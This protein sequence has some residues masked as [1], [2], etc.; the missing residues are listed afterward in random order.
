MGEIQENIQLSDNSLQK[1]RLAEK[2]FQ[3]ESDGSPEALLDKH[4]AWLD[5]ELKKIGVD[6][7]KREMHSISY[8]NA[9]PNKNDSQILDKIYDQAKAT[10]FNISTALIWKFLP[11]YASWETPPTITFPARKLLID[12]AN[13]KAQI[14]RNI[15]TYHHFNDNYKSPLRGYKPKEGENGD[16]VLT[17]NEHF[18]GPR[19]HITVATHP[20]ESE[21][22]WEYLRGGDMVVIKV[23]PR[24]LA[25]W[26]PSYKWDR[27][28]KQEFSEAYVGSIYG[29]KLLHQLLLKLREADTNDK[30]NARMDTF[31][32]YIK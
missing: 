9:I 20:N 31:G 1:L 18:E 24:M 19:G 11:H 8:D 13:I 10:C 5:A 2:F 28:K 7:R 25:G 30:P 15:D 3:L 29:L 12:H 16:I 22:E 21:I 23:I 26:L 27:S 17:T 32:A 6:G 4:E 14:D